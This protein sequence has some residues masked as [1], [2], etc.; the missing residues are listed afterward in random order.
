MNKATSSVKSASTTKSRKV[1][2]ASTTEASTTEAPV[3]ETPVVETPVVEAPVATEA[4]VVEAP[5]A[6]EAPVT[7]EATA[8]ATFSQRLEALITSRTEM[9]ATLKREITELRKLQRDHNNMMKEAT[10]KVKK[11]KAPRD[12]T[13]PKRATGFAEPVL[14][15][16]EL[17]SFLV[18]NKATMKDHTF[19][20]SSEA[21]EAAWPRLPVVSGV[22]VARTDVTSFISKYI[23]DHNLQNPEMKRE[24]IPDASLKKIF[25]NPNEPTPATYSYLQ[26]QKYISHHFPKKTQ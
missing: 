10:K 7:I 11:T 5:V 25:A 19:V 2:V 23:K 14:V 12:F 3:V 6:T 17:Y 1:K 13:K 8:D 21:D 18:K 9:V 4:P 22:P 24:I 16:S 20:P 26:L 15:S